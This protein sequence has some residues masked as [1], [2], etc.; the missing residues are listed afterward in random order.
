[1]DFGNFISVYNLEYF[2]A[3]QSKLSD[4]ISYFN[5]NAKQVLTYLKKK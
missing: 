5:N 2:Y 3:T 1:M 4:K